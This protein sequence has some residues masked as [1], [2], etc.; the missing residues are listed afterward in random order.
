MR[1]ALCDARALGPLPSVREAIC[2]LA[3][4]STPPRG[5]RWALVLGAV[6]GV[7]LL[8]LRVWHMVD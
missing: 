7:I 2:S 6:G 4:A 1:V 5:R 8:G 3:H